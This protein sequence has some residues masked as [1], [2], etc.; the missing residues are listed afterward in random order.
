V[1]LYE[2]DCGDCG[3]FAATRPMAAS[4][5]PAPCPTCGEEAP[6]VL[7]V[8]AVT[9]GRGRR[10]RGVPEPKLVKHDRDPARPRAA[11]AGH[12]HAQARPWML[13]H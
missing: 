10:R 3:S 4:A 6:R 12:A 11:A 1:P 2:Y 5:A 13:G 7:S 8:T 9:H